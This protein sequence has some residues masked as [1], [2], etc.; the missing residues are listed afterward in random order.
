MRSSEGS[1]TY[2]F[3]SRRDRQVRW[4]SLRHLVSVSSYSKSVRV[5]RIRKSFCVSAPEAGSGSRGSL[6]LV[7]RAAPPPVGSAP[8]PGGR[9]AVRQYPPEGEGAPARTASSRTVTGQS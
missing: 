2:S 9:G 8:P 7:V 1:G 6:G 5:G 4:V 3:L